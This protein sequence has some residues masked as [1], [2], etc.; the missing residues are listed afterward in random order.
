MELMQRVKKIKQRHKGEPSTHDSE[1]WQTFFR[2]AL[3]FLMLYLKNLW[4]AILVT[5]LLRSRRPPE[6]I[7]STFTNRAGSARAN[8]LVS[9]VLPPKHNSYTCGLMYCTCEGPVCSCRDDVELLYIL[10]G[11]SHHL[12]T[13]IQICSITKSFLCWTFHSGNPLAEKSSLQWTQAMS[14]ELW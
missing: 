14:N 2:L 7:Q 8:C 9:T 5:E 11:K 3:L 1:D 6:I 4:L 10:E 13:W 12:W